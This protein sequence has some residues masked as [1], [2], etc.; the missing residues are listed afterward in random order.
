MPLRTVWHLF[1][2]S[3][4]YYRKIS[5]FLP[6]Q[7]QK[8]HVLVN[9]FSDHRFVNF[10]LKVQLLFADDH[11]LYRERRLHLAVLSLIGH[12]VDLLPVF[13]KLRVDFALGH[14]E[15]DVAGGGS[16]VSAIQKFRGWISEMFFALRRNGFEGLDGDVVENEGHRH[17]LVFR[18]FFDPVGK[19]LPGRNYQDL[20]VFPTDGNLF[21]LAD[22]DRRRLGKFEF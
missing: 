11:I 21:H 12:G 14:F 3:L 8:P 16:V 9:F 5:R 7:V 10:H 6:L 13:V 22:V 15:F 17:G 20:S 18:V 4:Y 19:T 1:S 2:F